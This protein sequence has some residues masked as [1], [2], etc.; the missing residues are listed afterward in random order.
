M[1]R[2]IGRSSGSAEGRTGPVGSAEGRTGPT[3]L[4][5]G[6]ARLRLRKRLAEGMAMT[7]PAEGR[8]TTR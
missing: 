8:A 1:L 3:S 6:R 5:E 2:R 4:V 7:R